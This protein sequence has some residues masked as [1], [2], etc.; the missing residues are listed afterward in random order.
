MTK[1]LPI[2]DQQL[3][4][5]TKTISELLAALTP[6]DAVRWI[7]DGDDGVLDCSLMLGVQRLAEI[8][9]KLLRSEHEQVKT[10]LF[11]MVRDYRRCAICSAGATGMDV[12][13]DKDEQVWAIVCGEC[14][15][16]TIPEVTH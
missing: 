12:V 10:I 13:W 6:S 14:G 16:Q 3:V 15:A 7:V 5:T 8:M 2:E 1:T 9:R 4:E 11:T